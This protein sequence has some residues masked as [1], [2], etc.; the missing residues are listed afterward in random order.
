MLTCAASMGRRPLY[1]SP[2][3]RSRS[4]PALRPA[5]PLVLA[6]VLGLGVLAAGCGEPT[7]LDLVDFVDAQQGQV[8]TDR[9]SP[10]EAR[11]LG[12]LESGFRRV[13]TE[14]ETE[15]LEIIA[16]A[17][18]LSFYSLASDP[19][20]ALDLDVSLTGA[21]RPRLRFHLNDAP[22][23]TQRIRPGR[24]TYRIEIPPRRLVDGH[25]VLEIGLRPARLL[26]HR[27]RSSPL[28]IHALSFPVA[29][30]RPLRGSGPDAIR[31][32]AG[33][34]PG[35]EMPAASRLEVTALMPPDAAF[36]T[37]FA[38]RLPGG[39]D[40][41][42]SPRAT[43]RLS[44][45]DETGEQVIDQRE[46]DASHAG[47]LRVDLSAWSGRHARLRIEYAGS[48]NGVLRLEEP[49][50]TGGRSAEPAAIAPE[51][52]EAPRAGG[53]LR[54]RGG[55][56]PDVLLVLLDAARADAFSAYGGEAS[57]PV[58]DAL[59]EAGTRFDEARSA[60]SWTGQSVPALFTGLYP[61]SVGVEHWGSRIPPS[62]PTLAA[63][64]REAGYR[65][66]LWTQH[67]FYR[68]HGTLMGGFDEV[69]F[70]RKGDPGHLPEAAELLGEDGA[71]GRP[72]F[73]VVHLMPPHAPYEP[74][75]PFRGSLTAG[76]TGRVNLEP[77]F[78]NSFPKRRDP[79]ELS[80]ED[81]RYIRGRYLE[82]AAYADH[83]VG[84]VL[85]LYRSTGR[86]EE[87]LVVLTSDHGEAFLE[88]DRFLHGLH[89]WREY[90]H[91]PLVVRWPAAV[92]GHAPTVATPVSLVDV[93]PT[94]VDGLGLPAG[95]GFQGR[96]LLP[97]VFD[98]ASL[99]RPIYA[100]TRGISD[101]TRPPRPEHSL[102]SSGW[103]ALVQEAGSG[104]RM[105]RVAEDPIEQ[106]DL[107]AEDPARAL[108]LEQ[109][110][111]LQAAL[112]RRILETLGAA[113]AEELDAETVEQLRA[114]GY[115]Q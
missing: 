75:A 12:R 95:I 20:S 111:R 98:R 18:S 79:S 74:P 33:D 10:A 84:R 7:R 48:A 99:E 40:G 43:L 96:S 91:I 55:K 57:T 89:L 82:N 85:D 14:E 19:A 63:L 22:L 41:G 44:V 101:G 42:A 88:H 5:P 71:A 2:T 45:L 17:A 54:G 69:I 6:A 66:V 15:A 61:D 4:I 114:L 65:T 113:E 108:L 78:L 30:G 92:R 109:T 62:V 52:L 50:L 110:V 76:Y 56:A 83:L 112:N 9:I 47:D 100:Y 60:S 11:G 16:R 26:G 37:G 31:L 70:G 80:P 107:A 103:K 28:R 24:R 36:E 3:S 68:S 64:F 104:T 77:A 38:L 49:R 106:R 25:N 72:V 90:L 58:I 87:A 13:T 23:A 115:L 94:L 8:A 27:A 97:T 35:L 93:A 34:L 1:S 51:G 29:D 102:E 53:R 39:R 86:L 21:Q 46:D 81:L 67:P 105:Y 59:A 73:A 32:L